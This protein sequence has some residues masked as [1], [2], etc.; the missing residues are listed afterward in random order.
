M[1]NFRCIILNVDN[2]R[3][4]VLDVKFEKFRCII[5]YVYNFRSKNCKK[6]IQYISINRSFV[7]VDANNSSFWMEKPK[8]LPKLKILHIFLLFVII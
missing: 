4:I 2:F 3:C 7:K 1:Y 8:Y 5:F 6:K